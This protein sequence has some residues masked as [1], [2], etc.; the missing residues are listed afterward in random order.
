MSQDAASVQLCWNDP[1]TI[2]GGLHWRYVRA[3]EEFR[4]SLHRLVDA[5]PPELAHR[6]VDAHIDALRSVL[7]AV[8]EL[9]A[10]VVEGLGEDMAGTPGAVGPDSP[11]GTSCR[12][13]A[14]TADAMVYELSRALAALGRAP[15]EAESRLV[16]DAAH[17]SVY[18]RSLVGLHQWPQT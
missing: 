13:A 11:V 5:V 1:Q 18:L 12:Q 8:D 4:T 16:L 17:V 2:L 9:Q 6:C 10:G 14:A 3:G 15:R 7:A